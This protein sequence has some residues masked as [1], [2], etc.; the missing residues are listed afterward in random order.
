M[1]EG[2]RSLWRQAGRRRE[3]GETGET[4]DSGDRGGVVDFTGED[5]S[6]DML[7]VG[8]SKDTLANVHEPKKTIEDCC[9]Q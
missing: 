8:H 2:D 6:E 1:G 3:L 7:M 9:R 5:A 4:G